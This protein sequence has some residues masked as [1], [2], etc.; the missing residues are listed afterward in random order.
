MMMMKQEQ[1]H[2]SSD[3]RKGMHHATSC[4]ATQSN[5]YHNGSMP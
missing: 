4:K 5:A 1:E 2:D 3:N